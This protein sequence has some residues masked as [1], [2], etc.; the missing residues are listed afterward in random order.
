VNQSSLIAG[1][2]LAAFVLYL[3]AAN[4]LTVYTGVLWGN[5]A[6]P[7]PSGGTSSGSGGTI[8]TTLSTLG[9]IAP[10]IAAAGG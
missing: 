1:A 5:T 3:A 9:K 2:L 7:V 8:S 4:R 10:Y 6:A